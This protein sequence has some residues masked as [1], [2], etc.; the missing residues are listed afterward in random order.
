MRLSLIQS[1]IFAITKSPSDGILSISNGLREASLLCEP[2]RQ[3]GK[4]LFNQ[5]LEIEA[6]A[7]AVARIWDWRTA[8]SYPLNA[9]HM[10]LRNRA[11]KADG[12]ALS[13]QRLK[14][15]PSILR[16]LGRQS[17][18]QMS[19][20]QDVGGCRAVVSN[21][22]R[23]KVLGFIYDTNPLRHELNRKRDYIAEPK[24]DGYRSIHL[25]YRFSGKASSLPWHNCELRCSYGRCCNMHG[26]HPSKPSMPSL[27]KI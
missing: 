17:T 22:N 27:A 24:E 25:M 14:R 13:A 4:D 21:M 18:M 16:K 2:N 5:K 12:N 9:L 20:M 7:E 23:L 15:L 3:G 10:T 19:Q 8:H 1:S 6:R 11:L 26:L